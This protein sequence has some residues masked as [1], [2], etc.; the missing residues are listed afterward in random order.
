MRSDHLPTALRVQAR[1][2]RAKWR[3]REDAVIAGVRRTVREAERTTLDVLQLGDSMLTW[4]HPDDRDKRLFPEMVRG[5]FPERDVVA[6]HG[7]GYHMGV[8]ERI[9]RLIIERGHRPK[10]VIVPLTY[11]QAAQMW[12]HHP[13]NGYPYAMDHLDR[14]IGT[15]PP[16]WRLRAP[17]QVPDPAVMEAFRA[18]SHPCLWEGP[19]DNGTFVDLIRGGS[20]GDPETIRHTYA[21]LHGER[22]TAS[23]LGVRRVEEFGAFTRS[24]GIPVVAYEN[25]VNVETGAAA[26][27]DQFRAHAQHNVTVLSD[28]LLRGTRELGLV[29]RTGTS[30]GADSFIDPEDGIEHQRDEGRLMLAE[31]LAELA[32]TGGW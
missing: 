13:R 12:V 15:R 31:A 22:I 11:R 16:T 32:R 24:V 2:A 19:R 7:P 23:H 18:L 14:L 21:Y 10:L 20:R 25:P 27:G 8:Y 5:A 28:A 29:A 26:W 9:L 1:R 6:V 30:V 3:E 17:R 4:S